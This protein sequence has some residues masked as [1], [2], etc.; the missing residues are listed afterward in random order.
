[1]NANII[2]DFTCYKEKRYQKYIQIELLL[3][4]SMDNLGGKYDFGALPKARNVDTALVYPIL[5]LLP[6]VNKIHK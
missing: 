2:P 6:P 3:E 1:M 4:E 5:W